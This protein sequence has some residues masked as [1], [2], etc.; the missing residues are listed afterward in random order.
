MTDLAHVAI[1][2]QQD[3]AIERLRALV[4]SD[5]AMADSLAQIAEP[6][7]FA[8][9][10]VRI[11][12]ERGIALTPQDLQAAMQPDPLGL[13]RWAAPAMLGRAWPSRQ[14]L[15]LW[16]F[17]AQGRVY[18][19]WAHFGGVPLTASFFEDSIREALR[20]PF[21]R[22][23]RY[24]MTLEDFAA[25]QDG[26]SLVPDGFIFHMS[27]CG[28]TL[29]TQMLA[30]LPHVIAISE[31]A[32]IDFIAQLNVGVLR[33]S[34]AEETRY[35]HAMVAAYGR[36]RSGGEHHF[37]I[38]LDCW[39]ALALPLFRQAF[40][41]TP[42]IFLYREPLE[43]LVSQ[44]WQRGTQMVPQIV[45]ASVFGLDEDSVPNDEYCAKVLQTICTA[46]ADG[47]SL[48]GGLLVNYREL[49]AAVATRI[50]PHFGMTAN[51]SDCA[52]MQQAARMD[53]KSPSSPFSD[54]RAAKHGAATEAVRA[55]ADRYLAGVYDRLE[56]LRG[57][58]TDAAE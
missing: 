34:P 2:T 31:A 45:P 36:R 43:V 15:P 29:V 11:A 27:R 35:L 17:A 6:G 49:P 40:P 37:V 1:R 30:A 42:W 21:N 9:R 26:E 28:S 33:L 22:L 38:K 56:A 52:L 16:A 23:F 18:V 13:S 47:V 54:D 44:M 20:R 10:A 57:E 4:M 55:A 8:K 48:G 3:G 14:W 39:H 53:A 12:A 19:D 50:L 32:P 7:P 51:E 46:V 5:T 25:G 24:R 41:S 58:A